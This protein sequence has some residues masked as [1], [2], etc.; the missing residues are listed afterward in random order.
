MS[1]GDHLPY[2]LRPNKAIERLLFVELLSRLDAALGISNTYEYFGFGGPQMEDFRLL[3]EYFPKMRMLSIER[4]EHVLKRQRF[5]GPHTNVRCRLQKSADFVSKFSARGKSI[6]WLD[7]TIPAERPAQVAEFQNLLRRV[8]EYSVVKITLNAAVA[9]LGGQ[10]GSR[11]LQAERLETFLKDFSACFP[12]GLDELAVTANIFPATLLQVLEFAAAEVLRDRADW[13]FQPLTS[14]TYADGQKMLTLTGIVGKRANL[15]N[16]LHC[17]KLIT[18]EFLRG[19]WNDPIPIEVPELTLK[20]KIH[21][22]QLLPKYE[23]DINF[24]HRKLGFFVDRDV[25]KSEEK[26]RN[27]VSFQKHYP[28]FGKIAI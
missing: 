5:N 9:T 4:E 19:V 6:V 2:Q 24:I 15:A 14:A 17:H 23:D 8:K 26:L 22:N 7:Y 12:N 1:T 25:N 3:N 16:I 21:V 28:H 10:P 13:R 27:Y 11:K 18:W 20:E